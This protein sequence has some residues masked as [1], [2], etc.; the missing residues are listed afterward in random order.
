M[1]SDLFIQNLKRVIGPELNHLLTEPPVRPGDFGWFCREHS[2]ITVAVAKAFGHSLEL[3]H[4]DVSILIEPICLT[5]IGLPAEDKHWWCRGLDLPIIDLS[6]RL[7]F[8]N[9]RFKK[10]PPVLNL[11]NCGPLKVILADDGSAHARAYNGPHLI[12]TPIT[13][14]P[15]SIEEC[16][17]SRSVSFLKGP[18]AAQIT[19]RVFI[20]VCGLLRG[21]RH[22]YVKRMDQVR[23]LRDLHR[24][25]D[26]P[27]A[28]RSHLHGVFS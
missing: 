12:Y 26:S 2:V 8:F 6:A 13:R 15:Y 11:G 14:E 19:R 4:G 10:H 18:E 9:A 1:T 28:V 27:K 16:L 20:H 24:I 17:T 3:I 22:S 23:A 21:T 5:S 7:D 25:D